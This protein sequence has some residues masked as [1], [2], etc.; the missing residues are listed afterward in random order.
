MA[1][2]GDVL[3]VQ[4]VD[5]GDQVVDVLAE[6]VGVVEGLSERPQPTW[7]TAMQRWSRERSLTKFRQGEA[8]GRIAVDE[9]GRGALSLVDVAVV[10]AVQVE[11]VGGEGVFVREGGG[12]EREASSRVWRQRRRDRSRRSRKSTEE[13]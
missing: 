6:G 3:E 13:S 11:G 4:P 9:E 7:S 1:E 2:E 12:R 8:P 5:E 10:D